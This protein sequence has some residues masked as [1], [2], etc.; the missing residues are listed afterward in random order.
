M[1]PVCFVL[2]IT[3]QTG[4]SFGLNYKEITGFGMVA[5]ISPNNY[6]AVVEK[7]QDHWLY[8]WSTVRMWPDNLYR[9]AYAWELD[10][11]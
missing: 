1:Q 10:T 9:S 2:W 11:F 5:L 8:H 4:T 6:R 7:S 3:V